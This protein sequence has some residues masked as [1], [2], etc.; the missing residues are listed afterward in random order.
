MEGLLFAPLESVLTIFRPGATRSGFAKP[1]SVVPRLLIEH[2]LSSLCLTVWLSS[3]QPTVIASGSLPV[4]Y[5]TATCAVAK[6]PAQPTPPTPPLTYPSTP[7]SLA[8]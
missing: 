4:A 7:H 5:H 8:L 3:R 2:R 1:S 6:C